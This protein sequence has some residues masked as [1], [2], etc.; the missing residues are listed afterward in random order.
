MW[1]GP[2][3]IYELAVQVWSSWRISSA[4]RPASCSLTVRQCMPVVHEHR[5]SNLALLLT[6]APAVSL[7]CQHPAGALAAERQRIR[8][9]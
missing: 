6:R 5:L 7:T 3:E 8:Q 2:D 1:R 9:N 4:P